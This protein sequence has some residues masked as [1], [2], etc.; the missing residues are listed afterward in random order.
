[1][2]IKN[3]YLLF[4]T[5]LAIVFG[6]YATAEDEDSYYLAFRLFNTTFEAFQW[7]K[8]G[9]QIDDTVRIIKS[10]KAVRD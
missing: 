10:P 3:L 5:S 2:L 1:M 9:R 4:L 7:S 6:P 8:N